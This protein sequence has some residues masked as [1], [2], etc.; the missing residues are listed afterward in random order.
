MPLV[1][2]EGAVPE[3]ETSTGDEAARR[4]RRSASREERERRHGFPSI[5]EGQALRTYPVVTRQPADSLRSATSLRSV[6]VLGS[7]DRLAGNLKY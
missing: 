7:P 2:S 4:S 5:F 1:A 6:S 3:H